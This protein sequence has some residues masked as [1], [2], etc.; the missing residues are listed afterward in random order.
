MPPEARDL[1]LAGAL[2]SITLNPFLFAALPA[3]ERW[4]RARPRLIG[5]LERSGGPGIAPQQ[6]APAPIRDHAIIVGHGRVGSTITPVLVREGLPF[7][8]VERDR[9]RF[10]AMRSQGVPVIFGD[11]MA[12]GLLESAGVEHARLLIVATPDSYLA[13]RAVEIARQR[14]PGIDI[15]V[16]T[17]SYEEL[18]RLRA[19]HSGRI[20]M[21]EHELA[22][23]MLHYAL[24]HF[25][26]PPERARLLVE[27]PASADL[28][29]EADRR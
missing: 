16:R 8:V 21:G 11:A 18:A 4:L 19:E 14:N 13:R 10:E 6:E 17:H 20:I 28:A 26:V 29:A 24:R 27:D 15:V 2:F 22:R 23:A 9:P 7:L 12:P 25:G 3:I 5:V 1:I